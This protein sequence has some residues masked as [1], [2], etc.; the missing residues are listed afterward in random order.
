MSECSNCGYSLRPGWT[1]CPVCETQ[2]GEKPSK[3]EKKE[4]KDTSEE[5]YDEVSEIDEDNEEDANQ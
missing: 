5:E 2:V 3:E 1:K 4:P